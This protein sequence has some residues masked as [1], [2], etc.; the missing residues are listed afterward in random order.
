MRCIREADIKPHPNKLNNNFATADWP[1]TFFGAVE[2]GSL[3]RLTSA[4][5]A[6]S[7]DILPTTFEL[8]TGVSSQNCSEDTHALR[9]ACCANHPRAM[10]A[11][12]RWACG[13]HVSGRKKNITIIATSTH[14]HRHTN[15]NNGC[16]LGKHD[17]MISN[18][19]SKSRR[20]HR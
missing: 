20:Q 15:I 7:A 6:S 10:G 1:N 9:N 8:V 17:G 16:T 5:D 18:N 3:L 12:V 13:Q 14:A 19:S 4:I 2:G 11:G